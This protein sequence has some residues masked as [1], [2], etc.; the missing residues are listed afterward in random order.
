MLSHFGFLWQKISYYIFDNIHD[1]YL[2]IAVFVPKNVQTLMKIAGL[3]S[4]DFEA[5]KK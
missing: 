5:L 1:F 4:V 3:I 2:K